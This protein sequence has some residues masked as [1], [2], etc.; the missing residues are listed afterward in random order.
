MHRGKTMSPS[1]HSPFFPRIDE[2]R[3]YLELSN[4]AQEFGLYA[5]AGV[6]MPLNEFLYLAARVEE[7]WKSKIKAIE[8]GK[9]YIGGA[10]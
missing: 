8:G 1:M 4:I 9:V 7:I 6:D 3:Y 10:G 2:Q 5:G